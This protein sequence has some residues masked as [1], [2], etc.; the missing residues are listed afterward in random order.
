MWQNYIPNIQVFLVVNN[1][2]YMIEIVYI[3]LK[4]DSESYHRFKPPKL[5]Y[6]NSMVG[7]FSCDV[8]VV[9]SDVIMQRIQ[10]CLGLSETRQ[11]NR[12]IVIW[13]AR[14][15][16]A[17]QHVIGLNQ[18]WLSLLMHICITQPQWVNSLAPGRCANIFRNIYLIVICAIMSCT[19]SAITWID[20]DTDL[21][22]HMASL[23]Q[24]EL[25]HWPLDDFAKKNLDVT[26][27][28]IFTIKDLC[29]ILDLY[30]K[31]LLC[32]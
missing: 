28:V 10:W 12:H 4:S 19:F 22:H 24:N 13:L 29:L 21:Y 15:L 6:E 27:N 2:I 1:L 14:A 16:E 9:A 7:V 18:W 17:S 32:W 23:G 26:F 30:Q 20:V 8:T 5:A 31:Y 11:V 25:T 3:W